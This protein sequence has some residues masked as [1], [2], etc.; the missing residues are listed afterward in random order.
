MEIIP[1]FEFRVWGDDL[2]QA[3][4]RLEALGP[5]YER[6]ESSETYFVSWAEGINVKIRAGIV[7]IK[8]LLV[9]RGGLE[10]WKPVFKAA[11]PMDA[12]VVSASV[13]PRLEVEGPS[14][15]E[16]VI[17]EATF[18]TAASTV[19]GVA[20]VPVRK[21]RSLISFGHCRGETTTVQI[22]GADH[23]SVAVESADPDALDAA[24][25]DIGIGGRPNESYPA[26]IRR[27]RWV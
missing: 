25:V 27:L 10:Q 18:I 24:I 9:V 6:R 23:H 13:F 1:R 16:A 2:G 8:E 17:D 21:E 7:D 15:G 19:K 12:E 5:V 20:V 14:L 11:F 4:L 26:L 22:D 3:K